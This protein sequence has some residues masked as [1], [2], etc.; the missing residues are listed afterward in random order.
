MRFQK[1]SVRRARGYA[2]E[3]PTTGMTAREER[4]KR[5]YSQ[6]PAIVPF[7][8]YNDFLL[9][10]TAKSCIIKSMKNVVIYEGKM[11][12]RYGR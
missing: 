12:L 9:E 11:G 10:L 3:P 5:L 6:A 1:R 7:E 8:V 4:S 2:A